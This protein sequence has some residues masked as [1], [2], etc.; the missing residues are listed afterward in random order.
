MKHLLAAIAV[1]LTLA[2]LYGSR[3]VLS[4]PPHSRTLISDIWN[5]ADLPPV[6]AMEADFAEWLRKSPRDIPTRFADL[7]AL[8]EDDPTRREAEAVFAEF[9]AQTRQRPLEAIP[10]LVW[11]TDDNPA[12][13]TQMRLFRR[14]HLREYGEPIAI[15]TD[16]SNRETTKMVIQSL[17]GAG[18]DIIESYGPRQLT[19]LVESG[20][21]WD[22]TEIAESRGFTADRCFEAARSSFVHKGRQY[23]FPANV[24]YEVVLYHKDLFAE[25][26]IEA[27]RGGVS[28]ERL[29][30]MAA[31]LTVESP[32]IPGGKRF[33]I[34]GVHPW[35]MTLSNGARF[36]SEDGSECI[37]NSPEAVE[38]MQAVHDLMYR[39]RVMP[40]PAE[41]A[42]MAAAAGFTG[43]GNN[44]LYFASRL[45]AMALGGRWEYVSFARANRDRVLIPAMERARMEVSDPNAAAL[46]TSTI[47]TLQRDVLLPL[48]EAQREAMEAALT[49]EDRRQLLQVGI[50]HIPTVDGRIKYTDVGARVALV[51][52]ASP[53]REEAARFVEF[54][55][56]REYND[57]INGTF[58]SICGVI[59]FCTDE[60]GIS[61]PPAPLPGLEDFDSP[62]FIEAMEGAESQQLSEWI[63]PERL[64]FLAG[65]V[66][67]L[68]LDGRVSAAEAARLIED[69]VNRQMEANRARGGG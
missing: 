34:V 21:A 18:A 33:G 67:D 50:M 16:P 31:A 51:N 14:W 30:E 57:L 44:G 61:G 11:S 15:M 39:Y 41:T 43:G 69:R 17:G 20:I 58:D 66:M 6:A 52:R 10:L 26:G 9:Y 60:D 56:S 45:T 59:E 8:A 54:L 23:G 3:A 48:S 46:L 7:A 19:S 47:E 28:M 49:P 53:H 13:Q 63:G 5:N 37:F 42:S 4:Q 38:G 35:K 27:P 65:Q 64:G 24:G 32:T 1:L 2:T 25:A 29:V 62:I 12:R 22:L 40:T 55:A 36:F 68:L